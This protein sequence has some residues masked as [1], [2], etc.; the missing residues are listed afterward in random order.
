MPSTSSQLQNLQYMAEYQRQ[1][2][3][4][5]TNLCPGPVPALAPVPSVIAH[6]P[7]PLFA[8][9]AASL[10]SVQSLLPLPLP[11]PP[12]SVSVTPI[13]SVLSSPVVP[14][15]PEAADIK[16]G[17][18]PQQPLIN[19]KISNSPFDYSAV[20]Q[21][22]A[23]PPKHLSYVQLFERSNA[24][25]DSKNTVTYETKQD[26]DRALV[27]LNELFSDFYKFQQNFYKSLDAKLV[28][29]IQ[30]LNLDQTTKSHVVVN[31]KQI[32]DFLVQK[33]TTTDYQEINRIFFQLSQ[34]KPVLLYTDETKSKPQNS[35][36]QNFRQ[37]KFFTQ[38][39]VMSALLYRYTP[40][41]LPLTVWRWR[42]EAD[43]NEKLQKQRIYED[44][45]AQ[46]NQASSAWR[47][48]I[49]KLQFEKK[50]LER[51]GKPLNDIEEEIEYAGLYEQ[52]SQPKAPDDKVMQFN[53]SKLRKEGETIVLPAITSTT[54]LLDKIK[55]FM[56]TKDVITAQGMLKQCCLWKI[57]IPLNQH[58][59][60][61]QTDREAEIILPP[62]TQF[63][64]QRPAA[65]KQFSAQLQAINQPQSKKWRNISDDVLVEWLLIYVL[66]NTVQN[67]FNKNLND[68]LPATQ[69]YKMFQNGEMKTLLNCDQRMGGGYY[70]S[71]KPKPKFVLV[72]HLF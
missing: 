10:A 42:M 26:I 34:D 43:P 49:Q 36:N 59:A 2:Q 57:E 44:E 18:P 17:L 68:F 35:S 63:I 1:Q 47:S 64:V 32:L 66:C 24:S 53:E 38:G 15:V 5:R 23:N 11:P 8:P 12:I 9:P 61:I 65:D 67:V 60:C 25:V 45:L 29:A 37:L 51:Q 48:K 31:Y 22:V 6:T 41:R 52:P 16:H 4:Q 55:G 54:L 30:N 33:Y 7:T 20:Y 3:Q 71:T 21:D 39:L 27:L 14:N 56:E 13:A 70:F 69:T 40:P 58:W 72:A 46:Y 62:C 50:E 28:A 19:R